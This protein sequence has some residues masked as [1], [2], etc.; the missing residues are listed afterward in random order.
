[1][2]FGQIIEVRLGQLLVLLFLCTSLGAIL[3]QLLYILRMR[4]VRRDMRELAEIPSRMAKMLQ[5]Q[6]FDR[7]QDQR[8][9]LHR[10]IRCHDEVAENFV[11][12][13]QEHAYMAAVSNMMMEVYTDMATK[14][15][16]RHD[17]NQ[18]ADV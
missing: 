3:P 7:L 6:Y 14:I 16:E 5:R 13:E 15:K 11:P 9:M 1:M 12:K 2:D 17:A 8:E 10:M 18:T 4:S